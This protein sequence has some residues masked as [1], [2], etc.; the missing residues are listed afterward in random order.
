M[1]KTP[2]VVPESSRS[3]RHRPNSVPQ[4]GAEVNLSG[5]CRTRNP[6]V[7][8]IV[9]LRLPTAGIV[10][11]HVNCPPRFF[12]DSSHECGLRSCGSSE[13]DPE[14]WS[15]DMTFSLRSGPPPAK[16]P[17]GYAEARVAV[18]G[19]LAVLHEPLLQSLAPHHST[20]ALTPSLSS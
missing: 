16:Y 10:L 5:Q 7:P 8:S 2:F 20:S 4:P 19:G 18:L 11:V 13:R 1:T 15:V 3:K 6:R 17:S 14:R 9:A 12:Q